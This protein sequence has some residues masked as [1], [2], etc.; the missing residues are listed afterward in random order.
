M[1]AR[2]DDVA[3]LDQPHPLAGLDVGLLVE[4]AFHP[5][6][7][8]I[9]QAAR[10]QLHRGA[11]GCAELDVPQ[12]AVLAAPRRHAAMAGEDAGT[13]LAR[14]LHVGDHQPRVVDPGIGVDEAVLEG[15]FQARPE[16]RVRQV[17]RDRLGQRHVPVEM[18]V[19][20]EAQPQHPA[21]PQM[22]LMRQHETQRKGEV[23]RLGQQ[24]LALLQRL[25]HQPEL[26]VLQIAQAAMD[27][28]GRGRRGG[29]GK[30]VHLAQ[31][32]LQRPPHRIAGNAC[33]VYSAAHYEKIERRLSTSIHGNRI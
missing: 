19:E 4:E 7:G 8:G 33:T 15:G 3:A 28:L 20:E 14:R 13:H 16:L 29:A 22:R 23:R 5:W 25:A 1:Q 30:I 2:H 24:D 12:L 11:V 31:P 26:V 6:P 32:D 27:Q 18:V 21:W 10:L 17:D 9:D